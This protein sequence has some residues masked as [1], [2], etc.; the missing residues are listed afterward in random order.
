W[1]GLATIYI[2]L[3][4]VIYIALA[5]FLLELIKR[6]SFKNFLFTSL[7]AVIPVLT[8]LQGRR[9]ATMTFFI[10]IGLCLWFVKKYIPPTIVII[11]LIILGLYIIPLFGRLR[12]DVWN[13]AAQN[14][15]QALLFTSQQSLETVLEGD[16]LEL[17]NAAL[18]IDASATTSTYG[19]GTGWWDGIVFQYVPGQFLGYGFKNSLQFNWG[20]QQENLSDLY[21][22]SIPRGSTA[23]GIADAFREFDYYG[24]LFFALGGMIFKTLWVS[25]KYYYSKFSFLIYIG[26]MSPAMLAITH[27]I[28]RFWTEAIFQLLFVGIAIYFSKQNK[29]Q[30]I[31]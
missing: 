20:P 3:T 27:D 21:R 31:N 28:R 9:Q 7:A 15:W 25:A 8:I 22:Y 5:I 16:N 11:C 2:F 6:P 29:S 1:T 24:C 13:L 26:L 19:Y 14:D 17:R 12:G 30:L 18:I 10:I 23:T 4:K